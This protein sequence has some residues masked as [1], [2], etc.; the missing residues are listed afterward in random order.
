MGGKRG[1]HPPTFFIFPESTFHRLPTSTHTRTLRLWPVLA[2]G[3]KDL[4]ARSQAQQQVNR[5]G[6]LPVW[7]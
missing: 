4:L 7:F 5:C 2:V 6:T 3:F 1:N